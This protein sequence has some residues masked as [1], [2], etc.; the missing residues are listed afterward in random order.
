M[1]QLQ[2][3]NAYQRGY[4]IGE[5][6]ATK[7]REKKI[8]QTTLEGKTCP[9]ERKNNKI[10]SRATGRMELKM[11]LVTNCCVRA[12]ARTRVSVQDWHSVGSGT[13]VQ[14]VCVINVYSNLH[15]LYP[16]FCFYR[17]YA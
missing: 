15:I 4:Q 3:Y 12:R 1:N 16:Q 8:K 17:N 9:N 11:R 5:R 14:A 7:R 2:H 10:Y 6:K 13:N